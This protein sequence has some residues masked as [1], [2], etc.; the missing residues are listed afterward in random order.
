[1]SGGTG[2]AGPV[3]GPAAAGAARRI[4]S[5]GKAEAVLL[6]RNVVALLIALATPVSLLP[7]IMSASDTEGQF[8]GLGAAALTALTAIVLLAAVYYNLVTTLVARREDLVLKR[9]R[10]GEASDLEILAGTAAPAVAVAWA[11]IAV[12]AVTTAA[13]FD[14]GVPVNPLLV[15]VAIGLGTVVFAL[16]A[17]LS[18]A[19]TPSVE[20]A[21]VTT[22]PVLLVPLALCGLF[23][24]LDDLAGPWESVARLLPLTPVVDLMRLGLTGTTTDGRVVDFAGSFGAAAVPTLVL[25]AW[26]GAA[27]WAARRWFRWEPRQ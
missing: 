23:V 12:T 5:L 22:M 2:L 10:A 3:P 7:L 15:A 24:P 18:T 4:R 26:A 16:L 17:A 8:A 11:Q 19:V 21:Q 9:L 25:V 6:R 20:L 14:L 13:L 1:M 27:G